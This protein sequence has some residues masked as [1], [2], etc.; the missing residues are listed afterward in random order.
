M[1]ESTRSFENPLN[2]QEAP[3]PQQVDPSTAVQDYSTL[4]Q[5]AVDHKANL[6]RHAARRVG[7]LASGFIPF[8]LLSTLIGGLYNVSTALA[9]SSGAGTAAGVTAGA[10]ILGGASIATSLGFFSTASIAVSGIVLGIIAVKAIAGRRGWSGTA[11]FNKISIQNRFE[12]DAF[13]PNKI[14]N[15]FL[16]GAYQCVNILDKPLI[17]PKG[18]GQKGWSFN[19]LVSVGSVAVALG[20]FAVA[21][22]V[23]A[24]APAAL[25]VLVYSL[26][27]ALSLSALKP[28]VS[29]ANLMTQLFVMGRN[30]FKDNALSNQLDAG[31]G[32]E[33]GLDITG[34]DLFDDKKY[35]TE[36]V[37]A[38]DRA[39]ADASRSSTCRKVLKESAETLVNRVNADPQ[40]S[41]DEKSQFIDNIKDVQDEYA[42]QM[43]LSKGVSQAAFDLA[44]L[45]P[46]LMV[47]ETQ[48]TFDQLQARTPKSSSVHDT[49]ADQSGEE[50]NPLSAQASLDEGVD[51]DK[52]DLE[53]DQTMQEV[54]EGLK[55]QTGRASPPAD[56]APD[57]PRSSSNSEASQ[58][59][60]GLRAADA[61][62]KL[63]RSTD[64]AVRQKAEDSSENDQTPS[65]LRP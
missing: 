26:G 13:D 33:G 1:P 18:P 12:A 44:G 24:V 47:R 28:A 55:T 8:S 10:K 64:G 30:R 62:Q 56:L 60:G 23:P 51:F 20:A 17:K 49:Q 14:D 50:M 63:Q 16:K 5:A 4:S 40:M 21:I 3:V 25:S 45:N 7:M 53:L 11:L 27:A 22:A 58:G 19:A 65:S 38:F 61:V 34:Q 15:K 2:A 6:D 59:S 54:H 43:S 41:Q 32:K 39:L 48:A 35:Q 9:V 37:R 36:I 57:S 52:L 29:T 46:E 31:Y 42:Q